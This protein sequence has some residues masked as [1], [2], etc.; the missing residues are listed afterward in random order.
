MN[1]GRY[2]LEIKKDLYQNKLKN[3]RAELMSILACDK[4]ETRETFW[5]INRQQVYKKYYDNNVNDNCPVTNYIDENG[6][7]T[8]LQDLI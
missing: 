1:F 6:F 5:P 8:L 4:I 2:K 3:K 7:Y